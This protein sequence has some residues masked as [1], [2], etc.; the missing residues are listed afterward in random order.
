MET[1]KSENFNSEKAA[2]WIDDDFN[3]L[4]VDIKL[5]DTKKIIK[6]QENLS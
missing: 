2:T 5:K 3:P 1:P 4:F 6:V